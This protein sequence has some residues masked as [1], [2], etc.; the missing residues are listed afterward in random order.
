MLLV[1]A[2]D[3]GD[4]IIRD[5]HRLNSHRAFLGRFIM[6]TSGNKSFELTKVDCRRWNP[7]H[8][9][10]LPC[11]MTTTVWTSKKSYHDRFTR[12]N[13]DARKPGELILSVSR[14]AQ[15][16]LLWALTFL[17]ATF[18]SVNNASCIHSCR[19]T[20]EEQRKPSDLARPGCIQTS[21]LF[22][23]SGFAQPSSQPCAR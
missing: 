15:D 23:S 12:P 7:Q 21:V 4:G 17:L 19:G 14:C 3:R 9:R 11:S 2:G 16:D 6:A 8:C 13:G 20:W 22:A 5:L 18:K 10:R 1:E